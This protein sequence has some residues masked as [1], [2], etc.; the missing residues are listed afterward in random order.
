M[1]T[2]IALLRKDPDSDYGVDFPDFPSCISAG[3][4]PEEA[5]R[6][7]VEALTGHIVFMSEDG[8]A[9]PE[10]TSRDVAMADPF[11]DDA[12]PFEVAVQAP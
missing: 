3:R 5:R 11:N 10:P 4:T 8:D 2:Y 1:A 12:E 6:M 7:A 9:L